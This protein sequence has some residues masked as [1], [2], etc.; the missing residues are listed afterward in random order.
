MHLFS[1]VLDADVDFNLKSI[2]QLNNIALFTI[3]ISAAELSNWCVLTFYF[4]VVVQNDTKR[5]SLQ[6]AN[7]SNEFTQFTHSAMLSSP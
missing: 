4:Y 1:I 5:D 2:N 3:L 7:L 6:L